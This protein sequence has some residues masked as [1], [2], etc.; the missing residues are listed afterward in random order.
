VCKKNIGLV[1]V[2]ARVSTS[3]QSKDQTI[4]SQLEALRERVRED[5]FD[6]SEE[7]CFVDDGFSGSTLVR[8][9]LARLREQAAA[10]V[11][12]R[13]YVLAPDRL[14]RK[15]AHQ[16]V[17][18]EELQH[19]GV[20]IIFL[21]HASGTSAEENLLVQ[22][23]R[24]QD[25]H[26]YRCVSA[27]FKDRLCRN[28]SL[29]TIL[30]EEAVWQDACALLAEPQRIRREYERRRT[31]SMSE[32]QCRRLQQRVD[33]TKKEMGRLLDAH[34]AS[35]VD[36]GDFESRCRGVKEPLQA[37]QNELDTAAAQ[38]HR[39]QEWQQLQDSFQRFA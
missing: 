29:R 2:Y 18:L 13:S 31:D 17:L 27:N 22:M 7:A 39:E 36:R 20:E 35:L 1:A 8:P 12:E 37:L 26:Y 33:K 15:L 19:A 11:I 25:C 28:K 10:G 14:A 9:A 16:A 30:L 38:M 21:N 4:A 34:Q 6:L 32:D 5:G 24:V 3:Q 23:R